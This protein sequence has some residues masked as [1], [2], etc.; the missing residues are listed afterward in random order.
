V[1]KAVRENKVGE[2]DKWGKRG[3]RLKRGVKSKMGKS[4]PSLTFTTR[5]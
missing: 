4:S 2:G 1:E 5:V 3:K